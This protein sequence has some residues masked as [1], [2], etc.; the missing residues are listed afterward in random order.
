MSYEQRIES[1]HAYDGMNETQNRLQAIIFIL[2][3]MVRRRSPEAMIVEAAEHFSL[4]HWE[5]VPAGNAMLLRWEVEALNV[6][7]LTISLSMPLMRVSTG[8]ELE[9]SFFPSSERESDALFHGEQHT[10]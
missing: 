6:M 5:R 1:A 8:P 7:F 9:Q 4:R 3:S 10:Y 2:L